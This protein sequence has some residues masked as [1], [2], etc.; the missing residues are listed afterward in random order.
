MSKK[1]Q[2][3]KTVGLGKFIDSSFQRKGQKKAD[4]FLILLPHEIVKS[5]HF[6]F[7]DNLEPC[8]V[9]LEGS[10]IIISKVEGL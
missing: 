2:K 4:R 8:I 5:E 10:K 7:K 1:E 6:P 9:R 3:G